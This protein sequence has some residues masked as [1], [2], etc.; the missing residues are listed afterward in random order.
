M[1]NECL[2]QTFNRFFHFK[3]NI[4]QLQTLLIDEFNGVI[5]NDL[6]IGEDED[7]HSNSD[8]EEDKQSSH[9]FEIIEPHRESNKNKMHG[10]SYRKLLR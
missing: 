4:R 7:I 2:I 3:E 1:S 10:E 9:S 5:K 8:S 6:K